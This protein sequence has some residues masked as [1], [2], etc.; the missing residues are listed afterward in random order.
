MNKGGSKQAPIKTLD[1]VL[2]T[3]E[4]SLDAELEIL[5]NGAAVKSNIT[6]NLGKKRGE[7]LSSNFQTASLSY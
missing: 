2:G 6:T 4:I 1:K 3:Y 7:W 5:E